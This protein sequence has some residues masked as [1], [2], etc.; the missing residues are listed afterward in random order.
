[1]KID[2]FRE[3]YFFLSNFYPSKV[4]YDGIEYL[5]SEAAFQAQKCS[6]RSDRLEFENLNP[7]EAKRLGRKV[8]IREDWEI[9]KLDIMRNIIREKFNQ[10]PDITLKLIETGDNYLEEGN[11]WGDII[12]GVCNGKGKNLLGKILMEIREEIKEEFSKI[13]T[14]MEKLDSINIKGKN[15]VGEFKS[16]AEILNE[17]AFKWN[18]LE[19]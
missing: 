16:F 3:E 17:L 8:K 18:E 12:W 15:E 6:R 14:I 11:T 5:N 13:D 4:K 10:N 9:V 2:N 7:S 1:M 19:K